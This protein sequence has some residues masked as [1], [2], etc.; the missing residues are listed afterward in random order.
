MPI[1]EALGN[2]NLKTEHWNDIRN[3]LSIPGDFPLEDKSFNLG[4]L[5]A[6]DVASKQEEIINISV[7]AT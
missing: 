2:K 4:Q 3:I 5:I 6:F 1:V 7:T